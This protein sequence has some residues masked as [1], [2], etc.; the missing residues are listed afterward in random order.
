L[1]YCSIKHRCLLNYRIILIGLNFSGFRNQDHTD[2]SSINPYFAC[3]SLLFAL[4]PESPFYLEARA[5]SSSSWRLE[6]HLR[7]NGHMVLVVA[8]GADQDLIAKSMY[9]AYTHDVTTPLATRCCTTSG[10]GSWR[11][12]WVRKLYLLIVCQLFWQGAIESKTTTHHYQTTIY[13]CLNSGTRA[14]ASWRTQQTLTP[15]L[16]CSTGKK[17]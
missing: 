8:K 17:R 10:S 7:D 12:G 14:G 16:W 9:F 3:S 6:K 13:M 11:H 15:W 1:I 2:E 4:I 5:A